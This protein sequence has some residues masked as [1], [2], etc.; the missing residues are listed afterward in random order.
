MGGAIVVAF[1][2]RHLD[3]VRRLVLIDPL[4]SV[5]SVPLA[6]R[7]LFVPGVGERLMDWMGDRILVG[8]AAQLSIT[9]AVSWLLREL[10]EHHRQEVEAYLKDNSDSPQDRSSRNEV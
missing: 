4:V 8:G 10:T 1:A 3:R 2:D 7:L 6:L 5:P 9:E